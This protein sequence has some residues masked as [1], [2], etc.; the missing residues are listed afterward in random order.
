MEK[1]ESIM[2]NNILITSAG[3]RVSLVRE[4]QKELK[5]F[6]PNDKVFTA[7]ANPNFSS[8]CQ[9]SD[10]YFKVPMISDNNYINEL[11]NICKRNDI[12]LIIP[13]IDTELLILAKNKKNFEKFGIKIIVSDK[14]FINKCRDKRKIH[15]F[16]EE[17]NIPCAKEISKENLEFPVFIKPFNGSCSKG[18]QMV[19]NKEEFNYDLLDNT[20]L[21]FLEY[22]NPKNYDEFTL[23]LYYDKKSILKCVVP[24]LRLEV[25]DGEVSKGKTIKNFLLKY[26]YER[27]NNIKGLFGCITLQVFVSKT[28]KKV[29]GIEINPRFGGG[30]PLSYNA[31]ANF[32]KMLIEE[33]LLEESI[34]QFDDWEDNLLLLRYDDEILVRNANE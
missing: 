23:D 17:H 28:L 15:I 29:I 6:F 11:L 16:F 8:A 9:I 3:R 26:V 10:K 12:G 7:D 14:E 21:M 24:R 27:L 32:P 5:S 18:I 2:K 13:T 25:R 22:L 19:K 33:Y 1:I 20:E 31:G 30:Y 34:E 4:F